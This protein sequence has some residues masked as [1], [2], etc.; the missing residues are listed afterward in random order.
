[1]GRTSGNASSVGT[2]LARNVTAAGNS[3]AATVALAAAGKTLRCAC[4]GNTGGNT[5]I[6]L[7]SSLV[8]RPRGIGTTDIVE[9]SFPET[10][11]TNAAEPLVAF[12]AAIGDTHPRPTHAVIA[13]AALTGRTTNTI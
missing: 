13:P 5:G 8:A 9:R 1:M 11:A 3:I 10:A 12:C 4:F 2:G 6:V 7:A